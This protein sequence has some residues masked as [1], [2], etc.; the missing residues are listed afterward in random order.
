MIHTLPVQLG[1]TLLLALASLLLLSCQQ[2]DTLTPE[3]QAA[4]DQA[5]NAAEQRLA[6][7]T[8][9]I[10][11]AILAKQ[12]KTQDVAEDLTGYT[13]TWKLITGGQE[14]L[15]QHA[16]ELINNELISPAW[17][18]ELMC[19]HIVALTREL[20][21]QEDILARKTECL[22]STAVPPHPTPAPSELS[23]SNLPLEDSIQKQLITE[24]TS[25]IGSEA[26]THLALSSGIL[27][28]SSLGAGSTFGIS[29]GIGI[30]VDIAVRWIMNPS[31]DIAKQLDQA[32]QNTADKQAQLY[33]DTMENFLQAR[34]ADWIQQISGS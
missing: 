10:R 32:L 29:I 5:Y 1:R 24:L 8:D 33:H 15:N 12:E 18:M 20:Q 23:H 34:K 26:A 7:H 9:Q 25:I 31:G 13:A 2:E 19:H 21:D 30:I 4:I 3:Q 11:K 6:Y 27:G 14:T 17:C 22:L 16:Q 28:A